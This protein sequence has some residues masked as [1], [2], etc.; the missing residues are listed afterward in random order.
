MKE[1]CIGILGSI[2]EVRIRKDQEEERLTDCDGFTDWTAR[3][4][5]ISDRR[6]EANVRFPELYMK[7]V[8]RHEMR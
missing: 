6:E 2:W 5:V 8:M 7:K 1:F 3:V 4:I